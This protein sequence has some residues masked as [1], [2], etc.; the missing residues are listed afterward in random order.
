MVSK[1]KVK[2]YKKTT[3]KKSTPK[4]AAT[5]KATSKRVTINNDRFSYSSSPSLGDPN[6]ALMNLMNDDLRNPTEV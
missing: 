5:K 6:N 1:T 4:K 2:N 3:P